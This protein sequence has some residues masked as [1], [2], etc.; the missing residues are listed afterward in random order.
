MHGLQFLNVTTSPAEAVIV[1]LS[2]FIPKY[3]EITYVLLN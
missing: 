2:R 3:F 1:P